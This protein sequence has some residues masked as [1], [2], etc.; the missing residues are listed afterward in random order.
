MKNLIDIV[1]GVLMN[2][3]LSEAQKRRENGPWFP[4][5]Q[6]TETPFTSR[7]GLRLLYCWQ[8]STGKHAYLN[9]DTDIILTDEEARAALMTW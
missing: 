9:C 5:C 7:S 4:A 2:A 1:D 8:P 6:G 3:R